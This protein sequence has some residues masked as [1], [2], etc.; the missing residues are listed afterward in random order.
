M[1]KNVSRKSIAEM[2]G[3]SKTTVTRVLNGSTSVSEK[4]RERILSVIKECGYTQN[5]L[6]VNISSN[7]NCNFIAM[8]VPDMSNYYYLEMFNR[9]VTELEDY[10]YTISIY[11]VS[12]SNFS[13]VLDK[14]IQNRVS[15]IINPCV[16]ADD[17]G[18]SEKNQMRE[19]KSYPSGAWRRP[20]EGKDKL[21][22]RNGK[23]VCG[24]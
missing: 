23:S 18:G 16:R 22:S 13:R 7:K 15:A 5:K 2:A 6:A 9:M 20:C 3:V 8:L 4:T 11:R 24:A 10:D 14:V 19:H 1:E 12:R 21:S 17:R